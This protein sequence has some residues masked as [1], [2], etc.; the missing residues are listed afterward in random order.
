MIVPKILILGIWQADLSSI[1]EK[2]RDRVSTQYRPETD[3]Y[4]AI[5]QKTEEELDDEM[6]GLKAVSQLVSAERILDGRIKPE[7]LDRFAKVYDYPKKGETYKQDWILR[8]P[9]SEELYKVVQPQV[10]WEDWWE[11]KDIPAIVTP[12]RST[13]TIEPWVQPSSVNPY[14]KGDKVSFEGSNWESTIDNNVWA[15][16]VTGWVEI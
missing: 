15:P 13:D 11:F 9:V 3:D 6:E 7:E 12:I 5:I 1:P 8:D 4:L 16:N 10:T 14:M 2:Y